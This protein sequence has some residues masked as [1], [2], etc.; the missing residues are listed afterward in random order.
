GLV[1]L[2]KRIIDTIPAPLID[3]SHSAQVVMHG[4]ETFGR[5][6]LGMLDLDLLQLR[7]DCTDD[8][9][10]DLVL[11]AEDVV[12]PRIESL[13]PQTGSCRGIGE[14]RSDPNTVCRPAHAA[15]EEVVYAGP[16]P[17]LLDVN[18]PAFVGGAQAARHDREPTELR[19]FGR[20]VLHE[21]IDELPL[22]GLP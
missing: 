14:A 2:G 18:G 4:V 9:R 19:E 16:A 11:Q 22:F 3:M 7:P 13:R 20:D 1:E 10:G 8:V 5:P 6:S 12:M 15:F 21:A 17:R